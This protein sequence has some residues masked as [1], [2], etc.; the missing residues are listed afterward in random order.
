[1]CLKGVHLFSFFNRGCDLYCVFGLSGLNF[2]ATISIR[3]CFRQFLLLYLK[4]NKNQTLFFFYIY[5]FSKTKIFLLFTLFMKLDFSETIQAAFWILLKRF[6][7][8]FLKRSSLLKFY[9][10]RKRLYSHHSL[11]YSI[12]CYD[13]SAITPLQC[14]A[15]LVEK[16]RWIMGNGVFSWFWA[17]KRLLC[18]ILLLILW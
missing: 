3:L 12:I 7:R 13:K 18:L 15:Y 14:A 9:L 8:V 5:F 16:T 6:F 1:M 11:I 4:I 2:R 17:L 10:V